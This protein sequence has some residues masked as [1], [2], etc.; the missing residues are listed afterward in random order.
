MTVKGFDL[1]GKKGI[2]VGVTGDVGKAIALALAESGVELVI[3]DPG[4]EQ[5]ALELAVTNVVQ[6]GA[7]PTAIYLD[8]TKEPDVQQFAERSENT[9]GKIDILVNNLDLPF[10][11]PLIE[12]SSDDWL[13]V[14]DSNLTS[15]FN[16]LKQVGNRMLQRGGGRIVNI[17]SHLGDR[18]MSNVGAY[19]A[20]KGGVIQLTKAAALEWAP[21]GLYVN[22]IGLGWIEGNP[23]AT[24][25]PDIMER[26][27]RFVPMHRLGK[28]EEVAAMAVYLSSDE[29]GYI[30]GQTIFVEG[31]V[32]SRL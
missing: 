7:K 12:T 30:T 29:C 24:S 11:K 10:A 16:L 17:T 8:S 18:G 4:I 21:K 23:F 14:L 13:K 6:I 1:S 19:C 31:G 25:D 27:L 22:G 15:V 26:L 9:L 32:M 3:T 5:D 20:A 2:V 28:P